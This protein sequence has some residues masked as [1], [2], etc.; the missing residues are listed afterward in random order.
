MSMLENTEKDLTNK[1]N[2]L[3]EDV[4]QLKHTI[5]MRENHFQSDM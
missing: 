3:N 5:A 1:N 4:S 2:E